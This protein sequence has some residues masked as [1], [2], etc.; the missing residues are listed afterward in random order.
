M[1]TEIGK[2][3]PSGNSSNYPGQLYTG[4]AALMTLVLKGQD[5]TLE[6]TVLDWRDICDLVDT[7][8]LWKYL[9]QYFHMAVRSR[10][11]DDNT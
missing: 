11:L 7:T 10:N 9:D 3:Q 5:L 8:E 2:Y 1:K 6:T 4:S